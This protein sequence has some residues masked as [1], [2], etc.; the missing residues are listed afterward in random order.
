M[1][2]LISPLKTASHKKET[3]S[4]KSLWR[5]VC[6][7]CD[8]NIKKIHFLKINASQCWISLLVC[9]CVCHDTLQKTVLQEYV[10][11]CWPQGQQEKCWVTN[12]KEWLFIWAPSHMDPLLHPSLSPLRLVLLVIKEWKKKK[13]KGIVGVWEWG[14]GGT[15]VL[16]M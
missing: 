14:D 9:V 5:Y 10:E 6:D 1:I 16:N 7:C 2:I 13:K 12:V 3:H 4:G 11:S 15:V 8:N